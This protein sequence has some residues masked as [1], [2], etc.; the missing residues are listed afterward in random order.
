V[1]WTGG[2]W[3]V[4][5]CEGGAGLGAARGVPSLGRGQ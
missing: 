5:L 2:G 4:R 3:L 1:A